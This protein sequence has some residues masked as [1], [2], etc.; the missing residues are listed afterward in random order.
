MKVK[1]N[2]NI[3]DYP[4]MLTVNEVSQILGTSKRL[5]YEIMGRKD[6][7]LTKIG[8]H[9]KVYRD[10]FFEWMNQN[11]TIGFKVAVTEPKKTNEFELELRELCK[12]VGEALIK[13]GN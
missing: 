7:P 3:A 11:D 10:S 13:F 6:F 1:E 4:L 9:K 8:R 2:Q 5:A 12:T